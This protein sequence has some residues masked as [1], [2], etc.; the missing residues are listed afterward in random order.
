MLLQ[1]QPE[2]GMLCL[3]KTQGYLQVV[4]R[5]AQGC[6]A[7]YLGDHGMQLTVR[8]KLY[9]TRF[10]PLQRR[11]LT[12]SLASRDLQA[13]GAPPSQF[14]TVMQ[15]FYSIDAYKQLFAQFSFR[16]EHPAHLTMQLQHRINR[17]CHS[18]QAAAAEPGAPDHIPR[19]GRDSI[20]KYVRC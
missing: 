6:Q 12:P 13:L 15:T 5:P 19:C 4:V 1:L 16:V 20:E 18:A 3:L 14:L 17:F 2:L 10:C 7:K 11:L 9:L 8:V